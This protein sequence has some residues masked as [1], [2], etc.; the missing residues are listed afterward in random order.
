MPTEA[1]IAELK[2]RLSH[3]L[4]AV[5]QGDTVIVKDRL[6]PVARLI[7]YTP[8]LR[9]LDSVLPSRS[10]RQVEAR[11]RRARPV[12]LKRGVLERVIQETK[13]EW[14]DKW[15]ATESTLIPR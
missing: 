8:P 12:R 15:L 9:R 13:Q 2:G 3:Y 7:P 6:T 1:R 4:R 11:L 5:R 14:L 10:L